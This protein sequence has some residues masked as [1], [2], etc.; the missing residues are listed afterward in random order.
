MKTC[1]NCKAEKELD[2]FS[3]KNKSKGTRQ[4]ECKICKRKL[5][6]ILYDT[7]ANRKQSI[8]RSANKLRDQARD[9]VNQFKKDNPCSKCGETRFYVLD[10]HHLSDKKYNVSCAIFR[11]ISLDTLKKEIEKCVLLCAN[12]HRELHYLEKN[13]IDI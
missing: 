11:A 12:C 9:Y 1:S 8:R 10:F 5:D 4:S 6:K 13:K 2:D 3:F 7:G